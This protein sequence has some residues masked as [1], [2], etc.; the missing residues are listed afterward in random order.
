MM[1]AYWITWV[2]FFPLEGLRLSE[3]VQKQVNLN[4]LI[5]EHEK[6]ELEAAVVKKTYRNESLEALIKIE[7]L[8]SENTKQ[9][10][11]LISLV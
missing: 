6:F 2:V 5:E 10:S 11:I 7:S 4:A 8:I 9:V 1:W 3:L